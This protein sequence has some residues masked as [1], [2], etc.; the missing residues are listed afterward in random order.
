[1]KLCKV[2]NEVKEFSE[3]SK[4]IRAKDG[5]LYQCKKCLGNRRIKLSKI[6]WG[7]ISWII[8]K[9]RICKVSK[10]ALNMVS[11]KS[12]KYGRD[13]VCKE[14]H[15]VEVREY[16]KTNYEVRKAQ[17]SRRKNRIRGA[18]GKAK[19]EDLKILKEYNIKT[20]GLLTC[21][22][23]LNPVKEDYYDLE[24][25]LAIA[26]GGNSNIENL[27]IS[28]RDCNSKKSSKFIEDFA[29]NR[30]EYFN[31]RFIEYFK[32]RYKDNLCGQH[33]KKKT[34]IGQV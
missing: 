21:E 26:N 22:Y 17:R 2:C 4:N 3:F 34:N 24:H 7:D 33:S 13:T 5:L 1:M 31:Q 12:K 10:S 15:V 28:C 14:C 16:Y 9:C 8:I 19:S 30:I 29:P 6:D 11:H 20:F 25:I 18:G 32:Q 27:A 23:C